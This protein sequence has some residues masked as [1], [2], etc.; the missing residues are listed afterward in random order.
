MSV[1]R[2]WLCY[3]CLVFFSFV[4]RASPLEFAA[5]NWE[6]KDVLKFKDSKK[7]RFNQTIIFAES[8]KI[9]SKLSDT[10]NVKYVS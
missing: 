1:N 2:F 7:I 5:M 9:G 6:G 10:K 4:A 8:L 3:S